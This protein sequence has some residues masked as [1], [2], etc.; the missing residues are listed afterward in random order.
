MLALVRGQAVSTLGYYLLFFALD[1][2]LSAV[3]I[4]LEGEDLGL[5][6]GLL[7][8]RIAYRQL[9]WIALMRSL[10]NALAGFA[11]GWGKLARTGTVQVDPRLP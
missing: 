2:L 11:V 6:V 10:W 1:L 4:L 9:L 5:L 7:I 8:Q 3:A